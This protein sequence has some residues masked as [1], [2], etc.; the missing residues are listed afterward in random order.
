[1]LTYAFNDDDIEEHITMK[2]SMNDFYIKQNH[3]LEE[4]DENKAIYKKIY[5]GQ[6]YK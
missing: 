5:Y 2:N 3:T 6:F 1:M 4:D